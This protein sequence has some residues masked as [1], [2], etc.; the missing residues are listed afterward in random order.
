MQVQDKQA[1]ERYREKLEMIR[2]G[3]AIN[4]NETKAE[5]RER[6]ERAKKDVRYFVATYFKHYADA[7]SADF[8]V[9]LANRVKKNPKSRELVR[10]G[11]GLAKSVWCDVIIPIWLWVNGEDVYMVIVGNNYDKAAILLSDTQAEL[12]A[13]PLLVHDFGEQ[14]LNG[15]WTDGD[16]RSRDGRFIGKALG[17]GQSPRGLRVGS[18]RPNYIVPDDLED[19]DT[20]KNPKRQDEVVEW[21]LRDLIPTMDG[22][23]RRYL[24][25]NNDPWPR[26][27]QNLLEKRN[28]KWH[29]DLVR[30]YNPIT[31]APAWH[32][33]YPSTYYKE[34]E[35]DIGSI[36]ALAEYNHDPH[37]EGK[38][39][40]D[41]L[42]QWGKAPRIDHFQHIV[43]HWDVAFSG[44]NDYNA[45]KVWALYGRQFWHLKAFCKQCK[46]AD[47]I[48]FMYDYEEEL[49]QRSEK[50]IIVHWKVEEQF[51]NDPVRQA[52]AEVEKEK[53]RPLNLVVKK[54]STANK[55]DR[56]LTLHPYYQNGRPYYD[57]R[58]KS[59]ND[60]QVGIAQLKGIEPGYRTHDDGP[61]ADQQAMEELASFLQQDAFEPRVTSAAEIRKFSRNRF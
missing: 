51:W 21:I 59:S 48:R 34:V 38:V 11:R 33:K 41:D 47:A 53:G 30:A 35:E 57:E 43:G 22:P 23:V 5:Q 19:K 17:M 50:P 14:K 3:N 8:H 13:N 1:I 24:H 10:W 9:A 7:E 44:K 54:R 56:I 2:R 26:S 4:P 42:I 20:S 25:P 29:V 45:V 6:I 16:F 15:S 36:A 12:E 52:I 32:Q 61:D 55:F 60:M 28:A 40:T 31:Y 58:E 37:V 39:F 46:M 18:K 27:I 49:K